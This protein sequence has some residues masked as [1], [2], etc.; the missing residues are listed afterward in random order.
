MIDRGIDVPQSFIVEADE[1]NVTSAELMAQIMK[2]AIRRP[3]Q[4]GFDAEILTIMCMPVVRFVSR[5]YP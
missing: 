2:A 3:W 4:P 5:E 1:T